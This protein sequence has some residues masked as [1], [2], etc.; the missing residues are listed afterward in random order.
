MNSL[1]GLNSYP[2]IYNLGHAALADLLDGPVVVE[3]K[4]DGSQFSFGL[5]DG[6]LRCRSK[7]AKIEVSEPE[8]MFKRGVEVAQG[9]DLTPGWTYRGEYLQKPK[10]NTLAY[11]R[12]P[13]HHVILFDIN[14]GLETYLSPEEKRAEAGRLGLEVVPVV[15]VGPLTS[16]EQFTQI[17]EQESVLGGVAMEG[18]VIK[19]YAKFGP[20]KKAL[21]G[22]YVREA[23][24][25]LHAKEW[26]ASNPTKTDVVESLIE[27]LR[28]EA[29]WHKAIQ[30][31][32][33]AGLLQHAPQDIGPLLREIPADIEKE[34]AD[35]I[36]ERL[37]QWAW[38]QIKRGV[39]G[40]FPQWYKDALA[41]SMFEVTH[42]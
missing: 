5:I 30:H 31:L 1:K 4:I 24:R 3:E 2:S 33:D 13:T 32:R 37:F 27:E 7:G 14:T 40:G 8:G 17:V 25:E 28:T 23:F 36:K 26:K 9:L 20:D 22:K 38:P 11:G 39:T 21:M 41:K 15:H 29:R 18:V 34:C 10:H 12:I 35:L 6:E 16:F 19:N 42:G